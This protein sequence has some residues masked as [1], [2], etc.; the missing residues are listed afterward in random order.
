[1]RL[2]LGACAFFADE[3]EE[4]VDQEGDG[5]VEGFRWGVTACED[6]EDVGDRRGEV[7][8]EVGVE[9]GEVEEQL[10]RF[11]KSH[12]VHRCCVL[13]SALPWLGVAVCMPLYRGIDVVCQVVLVH[14]LCVVEICV[15]GCEEEDA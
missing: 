11:R 15:V 9:V 8:R 5:C 13:L 2:V 4:R 10:E 7:L 3:V 6:L 1:M 14:Q 12:Q